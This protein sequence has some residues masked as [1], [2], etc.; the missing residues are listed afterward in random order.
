MHTIDV[1]EIDKARH[2]GGDNGVL[3]Y[4]Q[5]RMNVCR[6]YRLL[7]RRALPGE[8]TRSQ[9]LDIQQTASIALGHVNAGAVPQEMLD[10]KICITIN[11]RT[12]YKSFKTW[13]EIIRVLQACANPLH[14][15]DAQESQTQGGYTYGNR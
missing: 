8:E 11:Q 1:F 13:R 14:G 10:D 3:Q 6:L 12:G 7:E 2:L 9:S 15:N 4:S 5:A